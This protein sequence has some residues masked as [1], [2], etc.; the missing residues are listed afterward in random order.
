MTQTNPLTARRFAIGFF[1]GVLLPCIQLVCLDGNTHE[2]AFHLI[3]VKSNTFYQMVATYNHAKK[4]PKFSSLHT[5]D[6]KRKDHSAWAVISSG[7]DP[8]GGDMAFLR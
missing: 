5:R 8:I 6:L 1:L 3:G 2:N 7:A 4:D